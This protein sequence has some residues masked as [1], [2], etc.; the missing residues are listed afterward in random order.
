MKIPHMTL[1]SWLVALAALLALGGGAVLYV[2]YLHTALNEEL[3]TYLAQVAEQ[4][5]KILN[6]Q[7]AG[8]VKTLQSA[9]TAISTY[10]EL[11]NRSWEPLFQ[12]ETEQNGFKRMGL[13]E[14]NGVASL[15]DGFL[16]DLAGQPHF[17]KALS[18]EPAISDR[19]ADSVDKKDIIVL[20]VPVFS[21]GKISRVMFASRPA[22]EFDDLL[23]ADS[24]DGQGYSLVTKANGDKIMVSRH[25]NTDHSVRNIFQTPWNSRL[26]LGGRMRR[27]MQQGK[28][29]TE[30]YNRTGQ[31]WLYVSYTPVGINDWY[32]L[33]VVP[34]RVAVQKT[35]NLLWLSLILCG[36]GLLV[37]ISLMAYIYLQNKRAHA[38]LYRAAYTDPVTMR[39]NWAR[40]RQEIP[41]VLES[42]PKRSY[43]FVLF[44]VNKFKLINDRLG[45]PKA[46]ELLAH[47]SSVLEGELQDGELASRIGAD[48][49]QLLLRYDTPEQLK[50]RLELINEKIINSRPADLEHFQLILS[51]GVYPVADRSVSPADM[52]LRALLARDTIKGNYNDIVAFYDESMRKRITQEQSI[53]N[54]MEEA[55]IKKEFSLLLAPI[56]QEDGTLVAAEAR[57]AWN[58]PGKD[59]IEAELFLSVF[60]K[61]GF[62]ARLDRYMAEEACRVL[63]QYKNNGKKT[64]PIALNLAAASLRSPYFTSVLRQFVRQ[65]KLSPSDLILQITPQTAAADL[66]LLR[67]L[68]K[69]LHAEGFQL[70]LSHFGRGTVSLDLIKTLPIDMIQ[71]EEEAI[72]D[73][74]E[75][76]KTKQILSAFVA[77]AK[78]LNLRLVFD[79]VADE[80]QWTALKELGGEF[81]EGPLAGQPTPPENCQ[82]S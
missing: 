38:V 63:Q 1:R 28:S 49:F 67:Q 66:P 62:I 10:D 70:A 51:F 76:P 46:N 31:G 79:G 17:E 32:L 80:K 23:L 33:S 81:F 22:E 30:H 58:P 48:V 19:I 5:V 8:D 43:A 20:A 2:Y 47:I 21:N 74:A 11:E 26:D 77:M 64:F 59:P 6:T 4:N 72:K 16:L 25:A 65:Y 41:E 12:R 35:K 14:P 52:T 61:N 68:A 40:A 44:D 34:E 18:G 45:Y 78:G 82:G 50:N 55:L 57:P 3:Q 13:V 15:S 36:T 69:Q 29:G 54:D 24:F 73:V 53:E 37:F 9:A 42:F 56:R 71:M 60:N 7:L 39:P 27:N 75:N